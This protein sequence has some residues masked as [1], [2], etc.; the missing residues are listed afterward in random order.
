MSAAEAESL[1]AEH[2]VWYHTMELRPGLVTPG[3][4]DLRP[5]VDRLPWPDVRGRRCLDV[6]T[7]DGFLAFE[8]ERRGAAEVVAV[9]T[10]DQRLWDWPTDAGPQSTGAAAGARFE[11]AARIRGSGVSWQPVSI[12]DLDPAVVGR[13]DVVVCGSVLQHLR[14]PVRALE[15]VRSIC[16]EW[17]LS[18]EHTDL[19]L[20]LLFPRRPV[21]RLTGVGPWCEWWMPNAAGHLRML[22]AAGF[23]AER[24]SRPYV[25]EFNR[26]RVPHLTLRTAP[27]RF[28]E[29]LLSGTRRP[30]VL[31]RAVLARPRL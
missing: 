5:I 24:V 15:A 12:Y 18:A 4:Y 31:H 20:S 3:T 9:D 25:H 29:R 16:S 14:D 6:G 10:E 27:T 1:V 17:L 11:I 22:Y 23:A 13:F 21:A 19:W 30:G 26:D 8:L 28:V 7:A 2:P